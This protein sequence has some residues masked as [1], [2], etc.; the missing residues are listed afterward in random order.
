MCSNTYYEIPGKFNNIKLFDISCGGDPTSTTN[1]TVIAAKSFL[2]SV[3]NTDSKTEQVATD[4]E[5]AS[6]L[7]K[8]ENYDLP[9]GAAEI[10]GYYTTVEKPLS[11]DETGETESCAAFVVTNGPSELLD[12]L[13]GTPPTAIIGSAENY[14]SEIQN[15]TPENPIKV[16]V[17]LNPN[18]EGAII[19]CKEWPFESITTIEN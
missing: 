2:N 13:T 7:I 9:F 12:T 1:P 14:F 15:S 5:F 6:L 17:T 8:K 19:G 16:L 4:P 3:Q 10:E 18:F 11:L